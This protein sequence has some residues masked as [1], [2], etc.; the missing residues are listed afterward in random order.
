MFHSNNK[1]IHIFLIGASD[2][3]SQKGQLIGRL[4]LY[5]MVVY[6][7]NQIFQQVT[8]DPNRTWYLAITEWLILSTVPLSFMISDDIGQGQM[9]Y[10]RLRPMHY[11]WLRFLESM[12]MSVI[13]F[14]LLAPMAFLLSYSLTHRLPSDGFSYG[15]GTLSIGAAIGFLGIMLYQLIQVVLGLL[16]FWIKDIKTLV[17]L[18]LTATFGFGGLIVPLEFYSDQVRTFASFTPYPWILWAPASMM[19]GGD[20]SIRHFLSGFIPWIF[21]LVVLI[22]F[23]Y[24]KMTQHLIIEGG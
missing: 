7:F 23:L 1:Y 18:N 16:S 22:L 8:P 4:I 15:I 3:L 10:F 13:R 12:G 9:A 11:L 20:V 2:Q 21:I 19:T 6:L 5:V 14:T 24:R 17:F